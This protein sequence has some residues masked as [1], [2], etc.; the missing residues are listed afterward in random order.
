MP[1][2]GQ[3]LLM[4]S[5]Q[6]PH[7]GDRQSYRSHR[8]RFSR[9]AGNILCYL[10]SMVPG[11]SFNRWRSRAEEGTQRH[12]L[13]NAEETRG[14]TVSAPAA[15]VGADIEM[16]NFGLEVVPRNLEIQTEN[17]S[18]SYV[19][20]R[21]PK[22]LGEK[23]LPNDVNPPEGWGMY[24][25]EGLRMSRLFMFILF[26]YLSGTLVFGIVW[27]REFGMAGPQSGF[28]AFGVSSWMVGLMSIIT[29]V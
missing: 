20:L 6:H 27:Y 11:N 1:L 8:S 24:F 15:A 14:N 29:M 4:H 28:G 13:R 3:S 22:K 5:W 25:E 18:S 7:H 10:K 21:T 16:A 12:I 9:V 23:L 26:L 19:L 17:R 2:V